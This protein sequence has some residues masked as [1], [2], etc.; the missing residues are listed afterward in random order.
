M[1]YVCGRF[2]ERGIKEYHG[3][4]CER[5]RI[6]PRYVVPLHSQLCELGVL[7]E[8]T[9]VMAKAGE[10]VEL[11]GGGSRRGWRLSPELDRLGSSLH[12]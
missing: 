6:D 1:G 5:F 8:P 9:S 7:L 2:I 4:G 11:I 10:Q 12:C 3:Y